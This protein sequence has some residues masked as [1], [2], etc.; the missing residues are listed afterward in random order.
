MKLQLDR[1]RRLSLPEPATTRALIDEH[2]LMVDA[3][4]DGRV[5]DG[6]DAVMAHARRAL[7]QAPAMR[8]QHPGYFTE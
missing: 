7:E 3:L 8:A 4:A 2:R 6:R 5:G 1:V